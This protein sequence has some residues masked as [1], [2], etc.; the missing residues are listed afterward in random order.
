MERKVSEQAAAAQE[1]EIPGPKPIAVTIS[2]DD[3]QALF[4]CG[5]SPTAFNQLIMAKLKDAGA[6]I[7][8]VLL[9]KPSHGSVYKL[10][11]DP[12][13]EQDAFCY[14]WIPEAW[15]EAMKSAGGLVH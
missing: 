6:P 3:I 12:L 1:P 2:T 7:E 15:G 5:T 10:K 11:D 8:G 13:K 4:S 14:M 9:L